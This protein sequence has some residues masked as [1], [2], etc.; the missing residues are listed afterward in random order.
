MLWDREIQLESL[1]VSSASKNGLSASIATRRATVIGNA[2]IRKKRKRDKKGQQRNAADGP[3]N[4][5][6]SQLRL[7]KI[8]LFDQPKL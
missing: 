3:T 8:F 6:R 2:Q 4:A 1:P 5:A 7:E